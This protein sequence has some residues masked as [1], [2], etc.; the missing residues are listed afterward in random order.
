MIVR[1]LYC[2]G[3]TKQDIV[4]SASNPEAVTDIESPYY[5]E[6][7]LHH[8]HEEPQYESLD[9]YDR[10]PISSTYADKIPQPKHADCPVYEPTINDN[11]K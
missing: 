1:I 8:V 6:M 5:E 11:W 2:S 9:E 7:D 3:E 10:L 4:P